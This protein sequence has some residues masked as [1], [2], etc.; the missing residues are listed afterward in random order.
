[1]RFAD[2]LVTREGVRCGGKQLQLGE[3]GSWY[4]KST[5]EPTGKIGKDGGERN[6]DLGGTVDVPGEDLVEI[7]GP[8][9]VLGEG[10]GSG[11]FK[12][13]VEGAERF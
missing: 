1:M 4:C 5:P 12:V 13:P 6:G 2:L 10:P 7:V 9:G 11:G 8:G 3:A